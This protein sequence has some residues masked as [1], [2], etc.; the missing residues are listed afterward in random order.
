MVGPTIA[1]HRELGAGLL[2]TVYEVGL[3]RELQDRGLNVER[4]ILL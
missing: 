1:V 2:E 4:Q 3:A